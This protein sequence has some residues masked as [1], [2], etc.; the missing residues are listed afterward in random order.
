MSRA[1]EWAAEYAR[2]RGAVPPPLEGPTVDDA[3][4]VAY[5]RQSG[6]AAVFVGTSCLEFDGPAAVALG[7]WLLDTFGEPP[8]QHAV[9]EAGRGSYT[10]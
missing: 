6:R 4:V 2:I 1:S 5:V 7:R 8:D 3:R 10:R 9:I